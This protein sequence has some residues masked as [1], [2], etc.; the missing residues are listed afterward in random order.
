MSA[1]LAGLVAAVLFGHGIADAQVNDPVRHRPE[2]AIA[3][4]WLAG[5]ALGDGDAN[6][7][8]REGD[9]SRLFST[10]SRFAGAPGLELRVGLPLTRRYAVEGRVGF[11]HPEMRTAIAADAEGAPAVTVAERIDQYTVEGAVVMMLD[12]WSVGRLVPFASGGAGYLRQL[13]EGQTLVEEG[14]VYH[15]GG[16]VKH[17]LFARPNGWVRGAG[18]RGDVRLSVLTGGIDLDA[19]ARTHASVSGSVYVTF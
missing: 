14:I 1:R 4:G 16:G 10:S 6:L 12:G 11:V 9:D 13:H 17:P 3:G 15:A 19:G 7:R 2:V 8:T 18:L 5:A